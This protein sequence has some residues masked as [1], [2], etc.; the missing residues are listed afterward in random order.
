MHLEP[1]KQ[2]ICDTCGEIIQ[3][4]DEG[5]VQFIDEN[6]EGKWSDFVIVHHAQFSPR[7]G[8]NKCYREGYSDFPL[9][10]FLGAD[11]LSRLIGLIDPGEFYFKELRVPRTSNFRKWVTLVRRLQTPYYEEAR[12]YFGKAKNDGVFAGPNEVAPYR[13]DFLRNI[14]ETYGEE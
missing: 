12:L 6:S 11:G 13:V 9:S 14:I 1:L 3:S 2:W 7:T 8:N 5:Y 4:P 10:E